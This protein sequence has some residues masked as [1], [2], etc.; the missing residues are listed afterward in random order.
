MSDVIISYARE[1]TRVARMLGERLGRA[2]LNVW[3]EEKLGLSEDWGRRIQREFAGAKV[4]ALLWSKA[5]A[6]SPWMRQMRRSYLQ[7]WSE[8]RLVIA[9]LDET[10]LPLGLGGLEVVSVRDASEA[11]VDALVS[12]IRASRKDNVPPGPKA[13]HWFEAA[14]AVAATAA[15]PAVIGAILDFSRSSIPIGAPDSPWLWQYTYLGLDAWFVTGLKRL[16]DYLPN[17]PW[18]VVAPLLTVLA[19]F[20]VWELFLK[21]TGAPAASSRADG[22][23]AA[24]KRP[25][26]DVFVSYSRQDAKPVDMLVKH[27]EDVGLA[28]WIDRQATVRGRFAG[29]IVQA[30]RGSKVV[31][32]MCSKNAFESH[33]VVR[34][35]YVAGEFK[36]PFVA[37]LLDGTEFPDDIVFFL[38]GFPRVRAVDIEALRRAFTEFRSA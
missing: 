2:H 25:P 8:D 31:A 17:I 16:S 6:D 9:T 4:V 19:A 34:E 28:T 27:I 33:H 38:S 20:A 22:G 13:L 1:D 7:A 3:T 35:V 11:G 15:A 30:I 21:D 26:A 29:P 18:I 10:P 14:V 12:R 37:L 23:A 5:A 32:L 36:K 24:A